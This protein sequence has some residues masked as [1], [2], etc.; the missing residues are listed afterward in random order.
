[1][2]TKSI[3]FRIIILFSSILIIAISVIFASFYIFTDKIIYQEVD[4]NL[5]LHTDNLDQFNNVSGMVSILLDKN[6]NVLKS[7]IDLNSSS[8]LFNN[9]FKIAQK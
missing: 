3:R 8:I 2:N 6:G 4:K 1:M 5:S 7:S 9:L